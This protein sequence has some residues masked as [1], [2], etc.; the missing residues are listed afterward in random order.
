MGLVVMKAYLLSDIYSG[1]KDRKLQGKKGQKVDVI[2]EEKTVCIVRIEGSD[3]GF[4]VYP[5]QLNKI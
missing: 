2:R 1:G 3:S 5:N 4:S